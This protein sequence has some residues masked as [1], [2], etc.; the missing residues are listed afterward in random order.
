MSRELR[1]FLKARTRQRVKHPTEERLVRVEQVTRPGWSFLD[2][3]KRVTL[4]YE[5]MTPDQK[6][7][8]LSS[9][10]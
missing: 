10:Q 1:D 3:G 4:N 6:D 9:P 8:V 2:D 7:R 5:D